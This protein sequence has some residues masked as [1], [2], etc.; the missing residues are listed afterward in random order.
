MIA[1]VSLVTCVSLQLHLS[2]KQV[3]LEIYSGFS[4]GPFSVVLRHYFSAKL[5]IIG[6][7][8]A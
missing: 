5:K 2:D 6:N 4:L 1:I 3:K 7:W 8:H